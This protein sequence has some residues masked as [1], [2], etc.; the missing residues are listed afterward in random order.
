MVALDENIATL[1]NPCEEGDLL[2][3]P[4]QSGVSALED[5]QGAD[6]SFEL[7]RIDHRI[8]SGSRS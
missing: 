5:W 7:L 8:L 2:E 3:F 1:G 4:Q 6:E